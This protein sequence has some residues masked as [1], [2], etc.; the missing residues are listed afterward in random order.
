MVYHFET[1]LTKDQIIH[2]LSTFGDT[3]LNQLAS[4]KDILYKVSKNKIRMIKNQKTNYRSFI[5]PFYGEMEFKDNKTY[6]HGKLKH[7]LFVKIF[8][9]IWFGGVILIGGSIFIGS[10]LTYFSKTKEIGKTIL[11]VIVPPAL[12]GYGIFIYKFGRKKHE[13]WLINFIK[14]KLELNEV[15]KPV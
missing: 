15:E 9:I 13:D 3:G 7:S 1:D 4:S 11:G 5:R 12:L 8:L 6:I 2:R 10:I 14:E